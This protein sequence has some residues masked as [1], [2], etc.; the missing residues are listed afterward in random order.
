[1]Y[2]AMGVVSLPLGNSGSLV[3]LLDFPLT[4]PSKERRGALVLLSRDASPGSHRVSN[5]TMGVARGPSYELAGMKGSVS[6]LG[7][8]DIT[9]VEVRGLIQLSERGILDSQWVLLVW[10]RVDPHSVLCY[11]AGV[12]QSLSKT[13]LF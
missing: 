5:N 4:Q 10:V 9:P 1:M 8:S 11:L 3:F 7:F 12:E 6:C 13:F 2:P